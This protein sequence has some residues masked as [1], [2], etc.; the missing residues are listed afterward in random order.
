MTLY[1]VI[2]HMPWSFL[3]ALFYT[4]FCQRTGCTLGLNSNKLWNNTSYTGMERTKYNYGGRAHL[5]SKFNKHILYSRWENKEVCKKWWDCHFAC[6]CLSYQCGRLAIRTQ[7]TC[8]S[9]YIWPI[10]NFW[11][12][13]INY[14]VVTWSGLWS[15]YVE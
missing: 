3:I 2:E 11:G 1:S 7:F 4:P 8:I 12:E 5:H 9:G 6:H 14:W 13:L 15:H 10:E